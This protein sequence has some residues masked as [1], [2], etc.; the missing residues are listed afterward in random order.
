MKINLLVNVSNQK[1]L[2]QKE[3]MHSLNVDRGKILHLLKVPLT[4][5]SHNLK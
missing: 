1:S 3:E 5:L 4:Q 2:Q